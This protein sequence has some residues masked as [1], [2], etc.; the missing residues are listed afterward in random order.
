[1]LRPSRAAEIEM[2][3]G[4]GRMPAI[5]RRFLPLLVLAFL[6]ASPSN[7]LCGQDQPAPSPQALTVATQLVFIDAAVLDHQGNFVAG[8]TDRNFRIL[9]NGT[10]SRIVKFAPVEAPAQVLVMLETSPAVY[11]IHDQHLI[12]AYALIDG[13]A[14]DDQVSLVSYDQEPHEVLK[15][16]T[17]KSALLSALNGVQFTIG[18]GDLNFY[19]SIAQTLDSLGPAGGKRAIVILGTGLDSSPL[20]HWDELVRKL[21]SRDVVIFCVALGGVLRGGAAPAKKSKKP[22]PPESTA[23]QS[24]AKADAALRSLATITGGRTYFPQSDEDFVPIYHEIASALRHQ[25]VIGV[26]PAQDGQFHTLTVEPLDPS[27]QP[28][29]QPKTQPGKK[30]AVRVFAREGYLAPGP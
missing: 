28:M 1:L 10:E 8:L 19:D 6:C 15:F 17:D 18:M 13:L 3:S 23:D 11:L 24:F 25:Y 30:P 22:A 27:G 9:D 2:I 4:R 7:V 29:N 14:A 12:A 20:A 21:R 16:T 5:L 26:N